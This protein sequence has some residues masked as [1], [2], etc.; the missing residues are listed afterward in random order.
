MPARVLIVDD[1]PTA[2]AA[3]EMRL[4][5]E[6]FEVATASDGEQALQ[7]MKS[8]PPD[9]VLLDV[10]MPGSMDTR[11]ANEFAATLSCSMCPL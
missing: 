8:D 6:Y 5:E 4:S 1:D 3:L 7:H 10:V 2:L 9:I 11:C